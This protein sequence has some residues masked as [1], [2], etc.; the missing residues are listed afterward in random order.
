MAS[1]II[2][3]IDNAERMTVRNIAGDHN[4]DDKR[5]DQGI[6][7]G[8]MADMLRD[9]QEQYG[10][11]KKPKGKGK[12][13]K[14]LKKPSEPAGKPEGATAMPSGQDAKGAVTPAEQDAKGGER[15]NGAAEGEAVPGIN[16]MNVTDEVN[17]RPGNMLLGIYRVESDA[18]KGGMGAVWRVHHTGW[19]VDLAMKRPRPEAFRTDEQK[20]GFI[21]ECNNWINLGL[22]PNVVACY[23]VREIG[24][25]P[26]IFSEWMA[27]GSLE[28]RIK[29]R[30]L[31][32]GTREE[33]R[34]RLLDIA[35]QFARGL[36]YAHEN[37]L[38][39]QDV[40]PDNLLLTEDWTAKVSDFGLAKARTMLTFLDGMATEADFDTDATMVSPGG[41]ITPAYC[42]PEQA[43]AQLL[44]RRTDLY[45]W[46]VSV[47]E[48]YLGDKPWAH[49]RDIT[50][51]L[52]GIACRDY[53]DMCVERPIP[54]ALQELLARCLQM[55]P[56]DRP[57]DFTVVEGELHKIYK[58]E[59]GADYLRPAPK[60]ARDAAD[61]LNNYAVSFLDIGKEAEAEELLTKIA[62]QRHFEGTINLALYKWRIGAYTD[63]D[64]VKAADELEKYYPGRSGEFA[65]LRHQVYLEGCGETERPRLLKVTPS[66][67]YYASI[68]SRMIRDGKLIMVVRKRWSDGNYYNYVCHFDPE[69]GSLLEQ[70]PPEGEEPKIRFTMWENGV[71]LSPG[72]KLLFV[73]SR[74][75]GTQG[76]FDVHSQRRILE[77]PYTFSAETGSWLIRRY[78]AEDFF[79]KSGGIVPEFD[80]ML[81]LFG[82]KGDGDEIYEILEEEERKPVLRIAAYVLKWLTG[83][84][85]LVRTMKD[86]LY[87]CDVKN[88]TRTL[89]FKRGRQNRKTVLKSASGD[90]SVVPGDKS[91]LYIR[92]ETAQD[93]FVLVISERYFILPDLQEISRSE[94][95]ARLS[96]GRFLRSVWVKDRGEICLQTN[97]GRTL[98]TFEPVSLSDK[99]TSG[100]E[101]HPD[102]QNGR[103]IYLVYGGKVAWAVMKTD[104]LTKELPFQMSYRL[105][106]PLSSGQA[107][108]RERRSQIRLED[109]RRAESD[110][111]LSEMIA[112]YREAMEEKE[113][114]G[115][116]TLHA[117]NASLSGCCAKRG[118]LRIVRAPGSSFTPREL[119][120]PLKK[121]PPDSAIAP[122]ELCYARCFK[123]SIERGDVP[124]MR[125][126]HVRGHE[127][128][129]GGFQ[130]QSVCIGQKE[131]IYVVAVQSYKIRI[132][133]LGRELSEDETVLEMLDPDDD[134]ETRLIGVTR[135]S[136]FLLFSM[137]QKKKG[138]ISI[139]LL[140]LQSRNFV[141]S[142]AVDD[143]AKTENAFNAVDPS[144]CMLQ[145]DD[146]VLELFWDYDPVS[147]ERV[148]PAHRLPH[149]MLIIEQDAGLIGGNV[150]KFK[151]NT[152]QKYYGEPGVETF[153]IP[154]GIA[155]IGFDVFKGCDQLRSVIIPE[156]VIEIGSHAFADC[157]HLESV[158][159]Q[160]HG[161]KYI[162][163]E[164][165]AG[166]SALSEFRIESSALVTIRERAF[167]NCTSLTRFVVPEGTKK[168]GESAFQG[169]GLK[170]CLLPGSLREL[171]K[172]AFAQTGLT[173]IYIPSAVETLPEDAFMYCRN[174]TLIRN[175]G[176][177]RAIGSGAFGGCD[178][179]QRVEVAKGAALYKNIF[180]VYI[181]QWSRKYMAKD[182]RNN[183]IK[184]T[185]VTRYTWDFDQKEYVPQGRVEIVPVSP[186]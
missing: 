49:G 178:S 4:M 106:R 137:Q 45:S 130:L 74:H 82:K 160:G 149:N 91:T 171:G 8:F 5:T 33:V 101:E 100:L 170:D 26:T 72:G 114:V 115:F 88:M 104:M 51:P 123:Y 1:N 20:Q 40:K 17:P 143:I 2:I 53:F 127:S 18:V 76:V 83:D 92:L 175:D 146:T 52:V 148:N 48:M 145:N 126:T 112:L 79:D 25:V 159:V 164:A 125:I 167:L 77:N 60:A 144:L 89:L 90:I 14:D 12:R 166:C 116:E 24:G 19:D 44:T 185:K 46:A 73:Y 147:L 139:N 41:G 153:K 134:T 13:G 42:S 151:G 62:E 94:F 38:I 150:E 140:D 6:G 65:Q 81:P 70:Y 156:S 158:I 107:M 55:D 98:C 155:V 176:S 54:K 135:D 7:T 28:N 35:I 141:R 132:A 3:V 22:H 169:S 93:Q 71:H 113:G 109:F 80:D 32:N 103:I 162:S 105:S 129:K 9:L 121:L 85:F 58:T 180:C 10:I 157:K 47:L 111:Q 154:E 133:C 69:T 57:K 56:E 39:H 75:K 34:E 177:I 36:H 78:K 16:M 31:Y 184:P 131:E 173:Q 43:A 63:L 61:S 152:L 163:L 118:I 136:R 15:K 108:E 96:D 37:D 110:G 182:R 95:M 117:M 59:T 174:L 21:D 66:G 84:T 120:E 172:G 128:I 86:T 27:K 87:L 179:L 29:D 122:D 97:S 138:G 168:I 68:S 124:T 161:L 99:Y 11:N 186:D 183:I 50:G 30:T 67:F 102:Y 181:N 119:P 64:V 142:F 23:Y 165:F